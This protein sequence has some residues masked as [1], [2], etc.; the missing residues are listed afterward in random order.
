MSLPDISYA[1][2]VKIN[3]KLLQDEIEWLSNCP[4]SSLVVSFVF[5]NDPGSNGIF[6]M[7]SQEELEAV[8]SNDGLYALRLDYSANNAFLY[9][10]SR[11]CRMIQ[12]I[13]QMESR[14][15]RVE[16]EDTKH[17]ILDQLIRLNEEKAF[18]WAQQRVHMN[19]SCA[20][21]VN[22]GDLKH[23]LRLLTS[24]DTVMSNSALF[25]PGRTIKSYIK[26]NFDSDTHP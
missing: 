19:K 5:C 10:E 17:M 7:P 22:T 3:L 4:V 11:Y 18:Q 6:I 24:S 23:T 26:S 15:A 21:L 1:A 13:R 12:K 8:C 9:A 16:M 25:L 20:I 14:I 2:Q